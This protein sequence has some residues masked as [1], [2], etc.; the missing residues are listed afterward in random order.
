MNF[1]STTRTARPYQICTHCIMDTSD[2][3][4]TFDPQGKCNHCQ[5]FIDQQKKGIYKPGESEAEWMQYLQVIKEKGKGRKYDC[6]LGISGGVDSSYLAHQCKQQGLRVLLMHLD[7]GW[8]TETAANNIRQLASQLGFDYICQVVPWED[9]KNVQLAFLKSNSVDLEMPTDIAIL[10]AQ[11]QVAARCGIKYILSAGNLTSEGILPLQWGYHAYKDM[12]M[13]RYIMWKYS[14]RWLRFQ[15]PT[16]GLVRETWYRFFHG[17]KT[18][19]PLNYQ[20]YNPH[21]AKNFL[22]Q[23]FDWQDYGIKHHESIITSFWH[24]YVMYE[25][26]GMDY[27]R[28]MFSSLICVGQITRTD[29][30]RNLESLPY[31]PEKIKADKKYI[32]KKLGISLVEL[33]THLSEPGKTYVDFPNMKGLIDICYALFNKYLHKKKV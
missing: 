20:P 15:V 28:A 18:L 16:I 8:N 27:R 25:K 21:A 1:S 5:S 30:L 9:F 2:R 7:N 32:A 6:L 3:D 19:Y 22:K 23:H 33:E 24:G 26:F 14:P 29:A 12:L 11:Y 4:I 10:A 13:Y 31:D 17:I